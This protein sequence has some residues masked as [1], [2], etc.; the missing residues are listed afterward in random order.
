MTGEVRRAQ[1]H[2]NDGEAVPDI[3]MGLGVEYLGAAALLPPPTWA[4]IYGAQACTMCKLLG[5]S[6]V[7]YLLCFKQIEVTANDDQFS[8]YKKR[9]A[10]SYRYRPNPLYVPF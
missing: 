8:M 7:R 10:L 9:M 2:S 5:G 1:P 4:L 6:A 3:Q